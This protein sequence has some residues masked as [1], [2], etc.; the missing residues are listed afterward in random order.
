MEINLLRSDLCT[1]TDLIFLRIRNGQ[2][3]SFFFSPHNQQHN[4]AN[5]IHNYVQATTRQARH[6]T[7]Q[8]N[9][10]HHTTPH[11]TRHTTTSCA[12]A[13]HFNVREA[14][15]TIPLHSKCLEPCT[16][17]LNKI[18]LRDASN[19]PTNEWT[20]AHALRHSG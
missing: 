18:F 9:T 1:V 16:E 8:H 2:G 17:Y 14:L 13:T 7:T 12:P 19:S 6:S 15:F 4:D 20:K 3:V 10:A 5:P 11:T